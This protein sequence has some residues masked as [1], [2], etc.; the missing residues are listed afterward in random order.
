MDCT[1]HVRQRYPSVSSGEGFFS[2]FFLGG[3]GALSQYNN[4]KDT[5]GSQ[6]SL[7]S[8]V[9]M[10]KL[11]YFPASSFPAPK[12]THLFLRTS[13]SSVCP[14]SPNNSLLVTRAF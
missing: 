12:Q 7:C 5:T 13:A 11:E 4:V 9:E 3:G 1:S 14:L 2:P 8:L 10:L 6:E